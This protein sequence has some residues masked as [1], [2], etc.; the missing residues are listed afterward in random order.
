M[1]AEHIG[2]A[3]TRA[4]GLIQACAAAGKRGH[5]Q[6]ALEAFFIGKRWPHH[7][8]QSQYSPREAMDCDVIVLGRITRGCE[9]LEPRQQTTETRT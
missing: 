6:Q 8:F 5:P 9:A 4:G 7:K 2:V 3:P 1:L